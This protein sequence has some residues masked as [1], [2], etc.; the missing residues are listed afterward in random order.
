MRANPQGKKCINTTVASKVTFEASVPEKERI[1]QVQIQ[2]APFRAPESG[3]KEGDLSD[4][5]EA[6]RVSCVIDL[7]SGKDPMYI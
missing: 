1:L 3:A 5:R 6:L 7:A 4:R 2:D